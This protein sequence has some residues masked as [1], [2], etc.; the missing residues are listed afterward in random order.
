M[1]DSVIMIYNN[2]N[3]LNLGEV[4]ELEN[5]QIEKQL[6]SIEEIKKNGLSEEFKKILLDPQARFN[7]DVEVWCN[8]CSENSFSYNK[9]FRLD[10]V[11][12]NML[13][14][15]ISATVCNVDDAA[16]AAK[17]IRAGS[18]YWAG[19]ENTG[20]FSRKNRDSLATQIESKIASHRA[21]NS[22]KDSCYI[23]GNF[24]S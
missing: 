16:S 3:N 2:S 8:S 22:I 15:S 13:G 17:E 10:I 7:W 12:K 1:N 20:G 5:K 21:G 18:G 9:E 19:N 14:S 23:A 11:L 6:P 4:I 24:L